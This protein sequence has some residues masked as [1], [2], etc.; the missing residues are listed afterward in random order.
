[1]RAQHDFF[2]ICR[3]PELACRVTLMPI[4]RYDLD[5]AIIFSDILVIP[6]ALGMEVL[7]KPTVGPVL[8]NPLIDPSLISTLNGD[9]IAEKLKYV[10]EAITLTRKELNGR[11]PLI[12]FAGAPWTIMSY[13]IEGGGSKTLSKAKKW[14]YKYP[15]ESMQLLNIITDATIDYL[16]MQVKAGAQLLQVFESNCEYLNPNLFQKFAVPALK[17]I[18]TELRYRLHRDGVPRVPMV[19]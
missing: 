2:E 13:M 11:V 1:M 3:T 7:M 17:R 18:I 9:N 10:G 16:E 4:E 5:A 12:G 14:L 19:S 6:Q 15:T 8:P